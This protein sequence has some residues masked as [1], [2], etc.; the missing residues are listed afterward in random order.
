MIT[1]ES[2]AAEV[3]TAALN[4]AVKEQLE[5]LAQ[6]AQH[7]RQRA[8]GNHRNAYN[9]HKADLSSSNSTASIGQRDSGRHPPPACSISSSYGRQVHHAAFWTQSWS[10][11][12]RTFRATRRHARPDH[13]ACSAKSKTTRASS[14]APLNALCTTAR[15]FPIRPGLRKPALSARRKRR[16]RPCKSFGTDRREHRAFPRRNRHAREEA[17]RLAAALDTQT[18]SLDEFSSLLPARISEAEAILRGV[19]DRLT[20]ANSSPANKPRISAKSSRRK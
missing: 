1:G 14:R 7:R 5:L 2:G 16:L 10:K 3:R 6:H 13:R 4:Q 11:V 18:R 12:A 8:D 9:A 17:E 20:P 19:A 15:S